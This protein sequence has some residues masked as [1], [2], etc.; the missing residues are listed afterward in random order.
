MKPSTYSTRRNDRGGAPWRVSLTETMARSPSVTVPITIA[1]ENWT[2]WYRC[3][4]MYS[5]ASAAVDHTI[6]PMTNT[7]LIEYTTHRMVYLE[8]FVFS[9][10]FVRAVVSIIDLLQG[11]VVLFGST[12][13]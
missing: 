6:R 8:R 9:L 13:V 4:A 3:N 1:S 12:G 7:A 10:A 5:V 11:V 2:S